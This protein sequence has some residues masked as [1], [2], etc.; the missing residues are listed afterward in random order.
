[1]LFYTYLYTFILIV[2]IVFTH[3]FCEARTIPA[4][5]N[6]ASLKSIITQNELDEFEKLN[7]ERPVEWTLWV[8]LKRVELSE[9]RQVIPMIIC[10]KVKR[11]YWDVFLKYL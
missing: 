3:P 1:M 11:L 8:N 5:I 7:I 10:F 9:Q 4:P 2:L 6:L